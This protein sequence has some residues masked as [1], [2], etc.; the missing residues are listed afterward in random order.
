[1]RVHVLIAIMALTTGCDRKLA[2]GPYRIPKSSKLTTRVYDQPTAAILTTTQGNQVVMRMFPKT[3]AY[4]ADYLDIPGAL[5]RQ[6]RPLPRENVRWI[7]AVARKRADG[8]QVMQVDHRRVNGS[9]EIAAPEVVSVYRFIH[10]KQHVVR[11]DG[12]L[13]KG[14]LERDFAEIDRV[15][16]GVDIHE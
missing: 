5:S 8:A 14:D 15:L 3:D 7:R 11:V 2:V 4:A 10:F 13:T 16:E 6:I 1:M 12:L 9:A